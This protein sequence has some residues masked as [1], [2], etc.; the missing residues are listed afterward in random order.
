MNGASMQ[1]RLFL[2]QMLEE[3]TIYVY[4]LYDL[5][6]HFFTLDISSMYID[7]L[8]NKLSYQAIKMFLHYYLS[9]KCISVSSKQLF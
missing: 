6:F 9:S 5:N 3:G 4:F 1:V 8:N 7:Y 2:E